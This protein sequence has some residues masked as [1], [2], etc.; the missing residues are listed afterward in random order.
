VLDGN[1]KKDFSFT[2]EARRESEEHIRKTYEADG[3]MKLSAFH[4]ARCREG[5]TGWSDQRLVL[6]QDDK[7]APFSPEG[8]DLVLSIPGASTVIYN[9][10][11]EAVVVSSGLAGRAK[12]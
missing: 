2:F 10:W 8:L 3:E 6:N 1:V 5:I 12:N 9:A 4:A 7:P 11:M